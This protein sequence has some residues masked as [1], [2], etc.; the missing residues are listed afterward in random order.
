MA[1]ISK[2]H[3]AKLSKA[4]KL[5]LLDLVE[6]KKQIKKEQ[7]KAFTPHEGQRAIAIDKSKI[8]ILVCGNG[9]GK[10]AYGVNEVLWRASGGNPITGLN[11]KVPAKIIVVLDSPQK[12]TDVWL[13][14]IKKWYPLTEDQLHKQGKP[15]ISMLTFLN[16][17]EVRFM[18]HLQE[19]LAFESIEADFVVFDE[20]PP[21]QVWVALMRAGRKKGSDP[22]YLLLG[23][24]IAQPWLREYYVEWEK[25]KYPDTQFFK[26]STEMNKQNLADNYLEEFTRHL[27]EKEKRTRIEGDFFSTDGL[28]LADLFKRDRHVVLERMLPETYKTAW[29]CVLA[30]DPHPNKP[31]H[32]CLLAASPEGTRYYVAETAQKTIPRE[33]GRWLQLNWLNHYNVVDIICDSSGTAD[34]TGGEGFR[35]FV[36]VLNSMGIRVRS[37]TYDEKK[38]DQFLTR[39]QEGLFTPEQGEPMLKFLHSCPGIV[40]DIENVAWKP[41]KGVEEYQPKLEIGNKDYLA[42]LKY[43]LAANLTYGNARRKIQRLDKRSSFMGDGKKPGAF[44]RRWIDGRKATE[45]D[46]F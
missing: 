31:V 6:R 36:E 32:A 22:K 12:V 10:T 1:K 40:R 28:A 3:L 46:D 25:G 45:D 4:E 34:F 39:I 7:R 33:F 11:S 5:K 2:E 15:F 30:L 20:P 26:Y 19:E 27:T 44:E 29:P 37:T 16:G 18:F 23:T 38:D 43:A 24:P 9:F 14:E 41:I 17:S 35:S 21:R 42:C 13:P 8:R